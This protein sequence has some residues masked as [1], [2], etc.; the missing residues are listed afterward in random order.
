MWQYVVFTHQ[1]QPWL[2]ESTASGNMDSVA[3]TS[4]QALVDMVYMVYMVIYKILI[5]PYSPLSCFLNLYY[6]GLEMVYMVYGIGSKSTT[7]PHTIPMISPWRVPIHFGCCRLYQ[8]HIQYMPTISPVRSRSLFNP[9]NMHIP[10]ISPWKSH[11][12][13]NHKKK[14][15]VFTANKPWHCWRY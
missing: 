13:V 14:A 8:L 6:V 7:Q 11:M 10:M 3:S 4:W 12:I 15:I 9:H 5:K 1:N 2:P